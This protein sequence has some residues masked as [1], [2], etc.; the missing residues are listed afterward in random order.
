MARAE[1]RLSDKRVEGA[2]HLHLEAV[3]VLASFPSTP[4]QRRAGQGEVRFYSD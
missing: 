2:G 1:L 3:L 4:A